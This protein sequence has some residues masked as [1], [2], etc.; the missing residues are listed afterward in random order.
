MAP[1]LPRRA[2]VDPLPFLVVAD[3]ARTV[4]GERGLAVGD[5]ARFGVDCKAVRPQIAGLVRLLLQLSDLHMTT[6]QRLVA[7]APVSWATA[8]SGAWPR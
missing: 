8:G 1:T 2:A 6:T 5:Q 7:V 3:R 4:V